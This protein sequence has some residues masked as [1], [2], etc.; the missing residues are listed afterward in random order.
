MWLCLFF[1]MA[2]SAIAS[3][4]IYVPYSVIPPVDGSAD[5]GGSGSLDDGSPLDSGSPPLSDGK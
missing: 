1:G 4:W 3:R 2:A 5:D